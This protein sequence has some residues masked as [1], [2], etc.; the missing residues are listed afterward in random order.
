MDKTESEIDQMLLDEIRYEK[1]EYGENLNFRDQEQEEPEELIFENNGGFQPQQQEQ[2]QEDPRMRYGHMGN[3]IYKSPEHANDH[4]LEYH[5]KSSRTYR[6][7]KRLVN[8]CKSVIIGPTEGFVTGV[9]TFCCCSGSGGWIAGLICQAVFV[10]YGMCIGSLLG[11]VLGFF[12]DK[13]TT[14]AVLRNYRETFGTHNARRINH[15]R[16]DITPNAFI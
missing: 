1:T 5:I 3:S 7:S 15:K 11:F 12:N 4:E 9:L 8:K 13:E 2:E 16:N 10:L 6:W 14:M